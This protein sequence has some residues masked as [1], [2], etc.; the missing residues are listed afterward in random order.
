MFGLSPE[1]LSLAVGSVT[2]FI[3]KIMAQ[4]AADR[5]QIVELLIKQAQVEDQL[6]DNAAKRAPGKSGEWTRRIIIIAVLFGVILAP[7]VLTI[8]QLPTVVEITTPV[9]NFLGLFN[10]G[11]KTRFYELYGYL[12]TP[13]I[14]EAL[15]ALIGFYFGV[16]AGKR[17]NS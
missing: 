11:G 13:Q 10:W 2:G 3:F 4:N 15:L 9:R 6:K 1:I 7:F 8:L 14:R 16:S 12:I 17:S 5:Q